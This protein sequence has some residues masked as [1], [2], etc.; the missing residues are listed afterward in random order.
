MRA[1]TNAAIA[2]SAV[3]PD[4]TSDMTSATPVVPSP[5][6][7]D[8][9]SPG[10][11]SPAITP[12]DA[13]PPASPPAV[14]TPE[15]VIQ[16]LFAPTPIQASWFVPTFLQQIPL[17]QIQQ[18][19]TEISTGLGEIQTIRSTDTGYAVKFAKGTVPTQIRLTAEGKI[20]GLFFEPPL[21]PIP[22]E[23]AIAILET[24]PYTTGL[25]VTQDGNDLAAINPDMPIAVASAF[26]LAVLAKL[27]EQIDAGTLSWDTVVELQPEWKSLPSGI[28]QDWP[29][30]SQLTLDTLA[31]L[32]ILISDNTAADALIQ[33]LGREAVEA[34]A[35]RNQPFLTTKEAFTLKNPANAALLKQYQVGSATTRRQVLSELGVGAASPTGNSP[36][37]DK[38]VLMNLPINLD[39]EWWFTPRELCRLMEQVA[40]LPAMQINP[41]VANPE[42]WSQI[43]FKGGT[44]PG[45][46]NLTTWLQNSQGQ[47]YCVTGTWNSDPQPLNEEGLTEIYQGLII[48]LEQE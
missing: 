29:D 32:M 2:Q 4:P 43:A 46:L 42:T 1:G 3:P 37:P 12:P 22:L 45:V 28:I 7:L 48:G 8:G 18:V 10:S 9:A 30:G 20:A 26:K 5:G 40:P 6:S 21:V 36:L 11:A 34:I 41:G 13:I 24:S 38:N 39:A 27:Q 15:A 31:T 14:P 35:P 47:T 44:E 16:R 25:L 19:L 23:E 17:A 33:I